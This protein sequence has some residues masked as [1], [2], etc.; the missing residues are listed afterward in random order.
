MNLFIKIILNYLTMKVFN[1]FWRDII[2]KLW[3]KLMNIRCEIG[4]EFSVE[5][6]TG[7]WG[8]VGGNELLGARVV[9]N[10]YE[11]WNGGAQH[12]C[13]LG[14]LKTFLILFLNYYIQLTIK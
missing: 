1:N 3:I 6:Y 2:F 14:P 11:C 5:K 13:E 12:S 9:E 7:K 4:K 10:V 8:E